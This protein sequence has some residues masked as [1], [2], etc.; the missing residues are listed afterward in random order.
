MRERKNKDETCACNQAAASDARSYEDFALRQ[1]RSAGFRI[2]MPRVQVIRALGNSHRA[3]S[4]YEIH[5]AIIS[6][7]GKIDVVSVYRILATMLES[8]LIHHIGVV[9]GYLP[10]RLEDAHTEDLEHM[11]CEECGCVLELSLPPSLIKATTEQ[12]DRAGFT[13][14]AIRLEAVGRCSHCSAQAQQVVGE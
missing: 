11:V 13:V 12:A 7:G 1:L 6:S 9:D 8:G 3:L 2:T 5:D 10:C 4:A 14:T